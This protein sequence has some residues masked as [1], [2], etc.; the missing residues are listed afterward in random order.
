MTSGH[1]SS[2]HWSQWERCWKCDRKWRVTVREQWSFCASSDQKHESVSPLNLILKV[3]LWED[4]EFERG[5]LSIHSSYVVIWRTNICIVERQVK[6][7]VRHKN[8]IPR[9]N[10]YTMYFRLCLL[11]DGKLSKKYKVVVVCKPSERKK[12]DTDCA[13]ISQCVSKEV[14]KDGN[15]ILLGC[16]YA[17]SGIA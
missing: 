15:V 16:L 12:V 4:N 1:F 5:L 6:N 8:Q 3:T 17:Q 9:W 13:K 14:G 7:L 11:V 10:R 2:T